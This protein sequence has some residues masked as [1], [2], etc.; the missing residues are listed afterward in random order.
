M[1][2][3]FQSN[4]GHDLVFL[5]VTSNF[6]K[7]LYYFLT[8]V[9]KFLNSHRLSKFCPK[10]TRNRAPRFLIFSSYAIYIEHWHW[11][12]WHNNNLTGM[13]FRCASI[14]WI[15]YDRGGL[16]FLWDIFNPAWDQT[17]LQTTGQYYNR[18]TTL[19]PYNLTT[20]QLYNLTT[21]L[22]YNLTTEQP[23]N[24]TTL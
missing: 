22:L 15:G 2:L 4:I 6:P 7:F 18:T 13:V 23:N 16:I 17:D 8:F 14:S 5:V 3:I 9:D 24:L 11:H 21:S 10:R 20:L 19:Q 12:N 1:F